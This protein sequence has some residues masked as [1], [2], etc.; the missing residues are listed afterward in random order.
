MVSTYAHGHQISNFVLTFNFEFR[1]GGYAWV[2]TRDACA[3]GLKYFSSISFA[4]L[5]PVK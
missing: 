5:G 4:N 1:D 3:T 2:S